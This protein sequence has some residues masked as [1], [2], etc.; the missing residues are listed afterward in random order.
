M[1]KDFD[2]NM[3]EL[4]GVFLE[5]VQAYLTQARDLE[6]LHNEKITELATT[7]V[8]KAAKNELDEDLADELRMVGKQFL[9]S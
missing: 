6:G 1:V 4:V 5:S 7:A 8:E 2:R 3:Q 9:R